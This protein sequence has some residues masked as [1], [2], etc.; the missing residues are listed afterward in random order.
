MSLLQ[1]PDM[2]QNLLLCNETLL[3]SSEHEEDRRLEPGH[4]ES[5]RRRYFIDVLVPMDQ[6]VQ[7][8]KDNITACCCWLS[9]ND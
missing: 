2:I 8:Y 5:A 3:S 4:N 6:K 9:V 7:A 1:W